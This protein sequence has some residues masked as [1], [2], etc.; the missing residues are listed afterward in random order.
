MNVWLITVGEP[1]P[2]DG[3]G[4]RLL[5]TGMLAEQLECSGNNVTW[6]TSSFDHVR[7]VHRTARSAWTNVT[8][9]YRICL[10]HSC[11]Y[12]RNVSF[13]RLRDH[14]CLARQFA[15]LAAVESAPDVIVCSL[16]TLEL[17]DE[18]AA[19]GSPVG[20]PVVL[21]VRDLW[22]DVFLDLVP[23]T[24]QPF[25]YPAAWPLWR[26]ARRAC[27]NATAIVGITDSFVDWGV[28]LAGRERTPLDRVFPMG[29]R[30]RQPPPD[31]IEA[32]Q[33]F[34][35]H[36]GI[37]PDAGRFIVCFFGS[38]NRHFEI[39]T[40]IEAAERLRAQNR[41]VQFVICGDGER[42]SAWK[43]LAGDCPNVIFPGWVDAAAIW[44]L[45]R[46]SDAGIAPYVSSR[47]F[48]GNLPNKPIEYL[49]AGLPVISSLQGVLADLLEDK[50]CGVTYR[51]GD[52]AELASEVTRLMDEPA[53]RR[54]MAVNARRLY[55][56]EFVAEH[57][58]RDMDSYLTEL[59]RWRVSTAA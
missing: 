58:Y 55:Q 32:A 40:I 18:A 53:L 50:Q 10:M 49:S 26:I 43:Q 44:T 38:I 51:N 11:G 15:E 42:R 17:C 12:R 46:M 37:E 52:A 9:R 56:Q 25:V 22:P 1:L 30:E 20:C 36:V 21:D 5:R 41:D 39:P 2:T 59:A 47:N 16:P 57:V 27:T 8:P 33:K 13:Q 28:K 14:R 48:I 35:R 34:W 24:V 54:L 4:G 19:F 3:D 7:K 29:Y 45:M 23:P 31:E 6:W